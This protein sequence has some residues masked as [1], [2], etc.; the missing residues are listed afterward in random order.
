MAIICRH[1]GHPSFITVHMK[2]IFGNQHQVFGLITL[3]LDYLQLYCEWAGQ[4]LVS[5]PQTS[6][7]NTNSPPKQCSTQ[8][9]N[10]LSV[11]HTSCK[12]QQATTTLG[13]TGS[14]MSFLFI[15]HLQ[16]PFSH[17]TALIRFS[18]SLKRT[19]FDKESYIHTYLSGEKVTI[20]ALLSSDEKVWVGEHPGIMGTSRPA[21]VDVCQTE[22][23]R[24]RYNAEDEEKT[25]LALNLVYG[26]TQCMKPWPVCYGDSTYIVTNFELDIHLQFNCF[27]LFYQII[28]LTISCG[29]PQPAGQ[30]NAIPL[31]V[32]LCVSHL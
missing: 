27:A 22:K 16:H 32:M 21:Y 7:V 30:W 1:V 26:Y 29:P 23:K 11:F 12:I 4:C 2:L 3:L 13:M 9:K 24:N 31:C 15:K 5:L 10:C 20:L 28:M 14:S 17:P 18:N 8:A 6:Q 19:H 25:S